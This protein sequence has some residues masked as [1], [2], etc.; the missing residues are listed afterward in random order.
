M[1]NAQDCTKPRSMGQEIL[2]HRPGNLI[3]RPWADASQRQSKL[4]C[5]SE[6]PP[7][8][9]TDH[10]WKECFG[11][12]GT[13]HVHLPQCTEKGKTFVVYKKFLYFLRG[14]LK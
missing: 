3:D 10:K 12:E 13:V 6:N 2:W 8:P 1:E 9:N 11:P 14:R 4:C 5:H 7:M